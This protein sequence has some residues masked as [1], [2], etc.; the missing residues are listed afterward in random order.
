[1]RAVQNLVLYDGRMLCPEHG[2]PGIVAM[3]IE[4]GGPGKF[5]YVCCLVQ[6]ELTTP[7]CGKSAEWKTESEMLRDLGTE[8]SQIQRWDA[9]TSRLRVETTSLTTR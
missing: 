1:M 8:S 9:A 3:H 2:G 7:A 6:K 4:R 5:G